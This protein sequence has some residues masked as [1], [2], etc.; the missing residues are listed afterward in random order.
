MDTT[1]QLAW[2][3]SG[4]EGDF[5]RA[6][7]LVAHQSRGDGLGVISVLN[8][9][10]AARR[11]AELLLAVV[12]LYEL[13]VPHLTDD[14]VIQRIQQLAVMWAADEINEGNSTR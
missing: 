12:E 1:S 10:A 14:D 9:A 4:M 3:A 7:A 2:Y 5:R 8:E 11:C 13:V 6:A